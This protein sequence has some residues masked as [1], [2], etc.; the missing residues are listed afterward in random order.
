[1]LFSLFGVLLYIIHLILTRYLGFT[2]LLSPPPGWTTIILLILFFGGAQSFFLG[3]I[4]EY[5]AQVQSDTRSRPIWI[6]AQKVGFVEKD[7]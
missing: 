3:I 5:L 6:E 1:M 4:G 2:Y 7:S